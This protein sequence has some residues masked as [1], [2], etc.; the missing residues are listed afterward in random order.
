MR[1]GVGYICRYRVDAF[2]VT[3][4]PGPEAFPMGDV[5]LV[6]RMAVRVNEWV[7]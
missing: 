6:V 3:L 1:W 4:G 7:E 2:D 5:W